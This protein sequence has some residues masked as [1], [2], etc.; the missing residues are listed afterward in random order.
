M[1]NDK[2]VDDIFNILR[3]NK[4][5]FKIHKIGTPL[6]Q[7]NGKNTDLSKDKLAEMLG[8]DGNSYLKSILLDTGTYLNIPIDKTE[9]FLNVIN[10]KGDGNCGLYSFLLGLYLK[11]PDEYNN[12]IK[13][14]NK[15]TVNQNNLNKLKKKNAENNRKKKQKKKK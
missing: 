15:S 12:Y 14:L 7:V 13:T 6:Q 1:S 3:D 10:V 9:Y 11:N 8:I 2:I 4:A 5:K